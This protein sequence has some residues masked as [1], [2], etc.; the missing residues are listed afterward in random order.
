[1]NLSSMEISD[2]SKYVPQNI[3]RVHRS[4]EITVLIRPVARACY[5]LLNYDLTDYFSNW[6]PYN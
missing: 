3:I 1:M 4:F 6:F 5:I 2:I